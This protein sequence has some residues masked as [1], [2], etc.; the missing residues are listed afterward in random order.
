MCVC[1]GGGGGG[2]G[3]VTVKWMLT[4][5]AFVCAGFTKIQQEA[6]TGL[7]L[8]FMSTIYFIT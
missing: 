7:L 3:Y 8:N 6:N 4:S 5:I 2:W 1:V